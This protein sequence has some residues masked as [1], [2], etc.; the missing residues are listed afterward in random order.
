METEGS[1]SSSITKVLTYKIKIAELA[2]G[3]TT[4]SLINSAFDYLLY[5]FVIYQFGIV[6]GG[7]IMTFLSFIACIFILKFYDWSKRDWLGIEAI[8]RLKGYKGSKK[9]G[10]VT[11]WF[12]NKSE[13]VIFLFLSIHHDPFITTAYLRKGA[14]NGMSRRD[15]KIFMGSLIIGNAYWTLACYIGITLVEWGWK[16]V[17]K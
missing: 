17:I 12:L 7:I 3:F 9:L 2:L 4:N 14:Y 15:W 16:M 6:K 1:K 10:K 11:A 8:K 13:P 5:P